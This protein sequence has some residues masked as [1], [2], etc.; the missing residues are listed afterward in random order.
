MAPDRVNDVPVAAPIIGVTKVGEVDKTI[1][2]VPVGVA[3]VEIA[4]V[5]E[6]V[7]GEPVTVNIDGTVRDTEVTVPRVNK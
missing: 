7:I 2:P 3:V 6:E 5:P 1:D 4:K